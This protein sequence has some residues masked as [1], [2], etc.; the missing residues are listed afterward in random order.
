MINHGKEIWW[1]FVN[2]D[3]ILWSQ[4]DITE[5]MKSFS[6]TNELVGIST[7]ADEAYDILSEFVKSH[8]EIETS[9][10]S[11]QDLIKEAYKQ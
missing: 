7:T 9:V 1:Y 3:E 10:H 5:K 11:V 8:P 2:E 6:D 4:K